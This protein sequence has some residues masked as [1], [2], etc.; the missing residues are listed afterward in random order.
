MTWLRKARPVLVALGLALGIGTLIGA[1]NLATGSNAEA[2]AKPGE[3]VPKANGGPVV[4]GLVDT[5]PQPTW[6]GLPPV[7]QSGT[8]VKVHVKEGDDVKVDQPLYEFDATIQKQDVKLAEAA[9]AYANTKVKEAEELAKQHAKNI[10]AAAKAVDAAKRK[11]GLMKQYYELVEQNLERG[12]RAE[13]KPPETWK[14]LKKGSADLYKAN[15]D[16][17]TAVQ[18]QTQAELRHEHLKTADPQVKVEEAKAAVK[19]AEAQLDKAKAAVDLCVVKARTAGTVEQV[20]ISSGTTLGISTRAP[21]LWL[22]PAGTRVVRAEVE[23]D[24]AH[25]V[26]NDI[27][28]KTVTIYDHTDPKLTYTGVVR[29]V[30]PVFLLK[31]ANAENFLGGDTR[32]IEVAIEVTDPSPAGRPPLRVGQRVRVNLG[33]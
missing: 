8:V 25:R 16:Y 4:L 3:G 24:F 26:G 23:A 14:E 15:V 19:Q 30:P 12:Y 33:Q 11:V 32:V 21:A 31:R 9:V 7:L 17:D 1:R 28:G 29:R 10:E 5:D 6:Y 20:S 18:E 22:I 27:V 2:G 13:G